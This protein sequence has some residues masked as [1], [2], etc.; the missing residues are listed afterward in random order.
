MKC[1][2]YPGWPALYYDTPEEKEKIKTATENTISKMPEIYRTELEGKIY[3]I[4]GFI[5]EG[6]IS[7]ST[8]EWLY[9]GKWLKIKNYEIMSQLKSMADNKLLQEVDK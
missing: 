8:C 3:R 1:I 9:N 2:K 5:N 6:I 4:R 7:G